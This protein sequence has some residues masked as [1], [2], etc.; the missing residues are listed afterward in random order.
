ME[1]LQEQLAG[2]IVAA[3]MEVFETMI[4]MDIQAGDMQ[5]G[6]DIMVT[7]DISSCIGLAGDVRGLVGV[8]CPGEVAM[9]ITA[10]MLGMEFDEINEDVQDA[11]GE[12]VNMVAGG[13][14]VGLAEQK[15]DTQLTVPTTVVGKSLRTGG[16]SGGTRLMV[17]FS[18]EQGTFGVE[19]KFV[20]F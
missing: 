18:V 3:T 20:P 4:F 15:K 12:I 10:A 8:H 5:V 16:L 2:Y 14:K 9:G 13:I 11:V 6:N 1:H 19:M 7:A 17:P